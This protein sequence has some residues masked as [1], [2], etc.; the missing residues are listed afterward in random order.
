M[1][2]IRIRGAR[3]HNLKNLSLDIPRNALVVLTGVSGS[4]KSSLAFDTLYAEG[5]RRYVESLSAYARQFLGQMEKPDVDQIEGLSPAI[6]IE[7]RT[8]GQNPRSTVATVTEIYDYLRLLFARAGVQHC[9]SCGRPIRGQTVQEMVD[10]ILATHAGDRVQVLAPVVRGRKGEYR[11]ELAQYRKLGFVRARVDGAWHELEEEIPLDKKRKHTIEILVDRLTAEPGRRSRIHESIETATKLA[12]GLVL[13]LPSKGEETVLSSAAA[14]PTCGR[15]YEP[16]EPRSFSFNS[17]YGACK[18]CDGLGTTFEIDPDLVVPDRTKSLREGAVVVWGDAEGTWIKGTIQAFAKRMKISMDTPFGKLPAAA[19]K[20]LLYG[21]GDEKLQYKFKLR[22]GTVWSHKGRFRGVIPE[23]MRRYRETSSDQVRAHIEESM[24]KK[25]CPACGGARLKP[26]SLAVRVA[27][28]SIADW[29]RMSVARS[30]GFLDGLTLGS[31][32]KVIAAPIVKELRQRL[33]FLENVG[34]GYLTLDRA[35]ATLAGGEAQRIRLA[36]QIGSRLTGVLYILDEPSVGLHP[37]DN[38]K[39][40]RTLLALRDLGNSVLVVEHDRETMEA[41]D[42]IV[43][44]GPGAGR[45]GGY[46]V[47]Q[48][49][50][51]DIREAPDSLTGQYLSGEREVE[52]P[53]TRRPGTS[54]SIVVVGAR[55]NNLKNVRVKF[56]LGTLVCVTGVSGSGK[57]TLVQDIL[58]R[59]LARHFYQAK[60]APGAHERIEGLRHIDKVV[61]IDQSPIGRTPRSNPATYTG[62]FS[63]IRDLFA[64]LPEA[65]VRGYKP[66][67]FSFNVKGGRCEACAGEGLVRIEMHFLPDVYVTCD[68]CRGKRYNRETLEVTFKGKSIADVLE[69]TVDDALEFL[70]AIPPVRRKLETLS[71][72]GLGYIHLGQP[73]TTLSGGEAQRVKLATE[74]SR[75][76]TGRTL[77]LLDEPT[78]GLHFE[79]VRALLHVLN[80]LVDK[81][82]TVIVIEHNLDVIQSADWIVDLG[83]EG[84]DGGGRVV[85]EGTPERVASVPGSH[86]G[87]ALGALFQARGSKG[88]AREAVV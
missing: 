86:T 40:L 50:I 70:T 25:P 74:L 7:Q 31:R 12:S 79:D 5:Q 80:R 37:R 38:R 41:A 47:A 48:G 32:E 24:S 87:E 45:R 4:G 33:E 75:V 18:T 16:P 19:Q 42:H 23:L 81:G 11:K 65:K 29:T 61:A 10:Q 3:E 14:C 34:V 21:L 22:S 68:V 46:L 28:R 52:I 35:A 55:E 9:L 83:P 8:A 73:A 15:S 51:E 66:G 17:P 82:N 76:E 49:T 44:L 59:A 27:D 56:P 2:L 57:S 36:T 85:A 58:Y 84:G 39:L 72:V 20:A 64:E 71:G 13:V 60:D 43:D 77:Y 63:F 26:E 53:E 88:R 1:D 69:L 78:T 54:E 6:S 30:L 67:R 62:V